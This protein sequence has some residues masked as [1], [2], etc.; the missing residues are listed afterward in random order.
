LALIAS[1]VAVVGISALLAVQSDF[2]ALHAITSPAPPLL[3]RAEPVR[4]PRLPENPVFRYSV[5]PGG[6]FTADEVETAMAQDG[7]VAAH[8]SGLNPLA[9]RVEKVTED[10]AVY[11]SYRIGDDVLWTKRK[12]HLKHG[13]TMLTDG[14]NLIRARC[15]N[16]IALAPM[17]PTAE[18]EP[19]EMEF[20]ALIDDSDLVQSRV[21]QRGEAI[22]ILGGMPIP[23]LL[24]DSPVG[25][26]GNNPTGAGPTGIPAFG[27]GPEQTEP[28]VPGDDLSEIVLFPLVDGEPPLHGFPSPVGPFTSTP[29][30]PVGPDN[31]GP[32]NPVVTIFPEDPETPTDP[33]DPMP[34]AFDNPVMPVPEPATLLLVG[35]GLTALLARRRR[36]QAAR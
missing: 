34:P 30:A 22:G 5:V 17:E 23:R 1:L 4:E 18:D 24:G 21:P 36:R 35:G 11:M 31:V 32:N 28:E 9:L 12:V 25:F 7:I 13:E 26:A 20:D 3:D 10:R 14:T 16:R 6:V 15:G 29:D 2:H 8:Y 33:D 19:G 27:F